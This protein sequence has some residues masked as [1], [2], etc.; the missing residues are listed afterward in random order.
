MSKKSFFWPV[1]DEKEAREAGGAGLPPLTPPQ[2]ADTAPA[3]LQD[4]RSGQDFEAS[5]QSDPVHSD[6]PDAVVNPVL[7]SAEARQ[8]DQFV[9]TSQDMKSSDKGE[10]AQVERERPLSAPADSLLALSDIHQTYHQADNE[11]NVL[12]GADLSI[13]AGEMVALV[14]PSGAGKS[15]LLHIAGLLERP[16]QGE[17]YID[18]EPQGDL[19]DRARTMTR[20]SK[21]GFVYQFHHLLAE[22]SAVE[23]VMLPQLIRG[24]DK[25]EARARALQLLQYMKVDHRADHRP[26]ELSGGEQQRVAIARAMANAPRVLLADEPT[27][28]LDPTTSDYVFRALNSLVK[29]SGIAALVA[30]HNLFLAERMDRQITLAEGRVVEL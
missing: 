8:T 10:N 17:V 14:A 13:K 20:R 19:I 23:N 18:G 15:T 4:Q 11:L 9:E 26:S 27:G 30:T 24:E 21:I 12:I 29:Q 25:S 7:P 2:I 22:F 6:H 1:L 16:V 3:R 5:A 28:N